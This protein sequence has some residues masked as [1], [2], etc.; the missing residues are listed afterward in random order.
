MG[1]RAVDEG[2][3]PGYLA[4]EVEVSFVI[5]C[6]NEANTLDMVISEIQETMIDSGYAY[7]I[8]VADNGSTD[9]SIEIAESSGARVVCV[10]NKGYGAALDGGIR[11][12]YGQLVVMFDADFTYDAHGVIPMLAAMRERG[13]SM[14]IGSRLRGTIQPGAMPFSHRYIG[15]PMLTFLINLFLRGKISD[16]NSGMRLFSKEHYLTWEIRSSGME[17]ASEMIVSSLL[18][19]NSI[20]EVPINFR[21]DLRDRAPHL[22]RWNDGMRHLLLILSRAP[23][24]FILAGL[25]MTVVTFIL[26]VV[27]LF[28]PFALGEARLFGDHT[29]IFS[30]LFGFFGAQMLTQ[31]V[32]LDIRS[33]RTGIGRRLLDMR[34][35]KLWWS[36]VGI[37]LLNIALFVGL[38]SSWSRQQFH[39]L[40]YLNLSLFVVYLV[41]TVGSLTLGVFNAHIL[42]RVA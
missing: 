5:P 28:G 17:F 10:K 31:G 2:F 32:T 24:P 6:L 13:S 35:S 21:K 12:A 20:S 36:I 18:S 37:A 39:H 11:G 40:S 3:H 29:L 7:E 33:K 34:E 19:G 38:F 16:C 23:E 25:A 4:D 9:G 22:R 42:K 41:T 27:S 15:T 30:I 1:I 14:V 26:S 8:V